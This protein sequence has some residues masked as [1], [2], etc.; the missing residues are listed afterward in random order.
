MRPSYY[1]YDG[2]GEFGDRCIDVCEATGLARVTAPEEATF[3]VAPK[4]TKFL[5]RHDWSSPLLGTLI[6]HPSILPYHRG[7]DAIRWAVLQGERVSGVTWFW[8]D[9]G[10]D[11]GP[12]CEQEPVLLR[13]GESPGRAYHTRFVPAGVR[14]FERAVK[15]ILIGAPRR[16]KQ[17][18]EIGTYESFH[19]SNQHEKAAFTAKVAQ[20]SSEAAD[21]HET[22]AGTANNGF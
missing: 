12:I 21:M 2:A 19:C 10:V 15:G 6:F 1:I 7:P 4:L 3:S 9:D 14:A 17:E 11:T 13:P 22:R 5:S 20:T 8:C 18:A 16:V